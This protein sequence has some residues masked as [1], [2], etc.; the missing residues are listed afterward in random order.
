MT[1]DKDGQINILKTEGSEVENK[2]KIK[3]INK[4]KKIKGS[5]VKMPT[6]SVLSY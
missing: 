6:N 3:K 5:E 4:N 1:I 2:I